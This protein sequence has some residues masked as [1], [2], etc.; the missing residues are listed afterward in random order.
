MSEATLGES[1]PHV[2]NRY[3][4]LANLYEGTGRVDDSKLIWEKVEELR[5]K[6]QLELD[7]WDQ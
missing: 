1:H 4:N 5:A 6:R 2:I 7:S 3:R